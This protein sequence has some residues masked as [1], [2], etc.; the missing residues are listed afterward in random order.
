MRLDKLTNKFQLALADAQSIAVGKDH[1]FIEPLHLLKALLA[2]EGGLIAQLLLQAGADL[3][4]LNASLD[5][6][7][8]N[9]PHVEGTAGE[10]HVSNEF[11]SLIEC[12]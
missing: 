1:G 11:K 5:H 6:A 8:N 7:L 12:N 10:V 2:Q 9:L 3:T 4:Q